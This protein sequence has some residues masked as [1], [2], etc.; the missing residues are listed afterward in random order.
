METCMNESTL[1]PTSVDVSQLD[2][3]ASALLDVARFVETHC[4]GEMHTIADALGRP[5]N[6]H[7]ESADYQF[8][9]RATFFGGFRSAF[10]VQE[11]NDSAYR[12]VQKSLHELVEHLNWSAEATKKI[13]RDYRTIEATNQAMGQD[14]ERALLG[15]DLTPPPNGRTR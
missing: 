2:G 11:R 1:P 8:T 5:T 14:I 9:R 6:V 4:L 10:A 3:A 15:Y 12:A 13:A 7:D